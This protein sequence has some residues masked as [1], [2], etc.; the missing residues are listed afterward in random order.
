MDTYWLLRVY[1][2]ISH[3]GTSSRK[4]LRN[5]ENYKTQKEIEG[6]PNKHKDILCLDYDPPHDL[7]TQQN[8]Y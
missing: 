3:Y 7:Y 2:K 5:Y 1:I 4:E 8:P 6:S